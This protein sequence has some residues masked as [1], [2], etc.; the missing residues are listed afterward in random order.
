MPND[1][2]A[3]SGDDLEL[4]RKWIKSKGI[5]KCPLCG[6]QANWSLIEHV[7]HAP[8]FTPGKMVIG[9]PGS[10]YPMVVLACGK[11]GLFQFFSATAMGIV[12]SDGQSKGE[13]ASNG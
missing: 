7:L 2:G 13:G 11:C 5:L 6:P 1:N 8:V 9:G 4:V 12:T 3:L 10:A